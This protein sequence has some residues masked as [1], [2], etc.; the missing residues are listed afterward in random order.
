MVKGYDLRQ[1]EVIDID[2]A[3]RLGFVYDVDVELE[4]GLIRSVI[5]PRVH[6]IFRLFS[7]EQDYVIP[8]ENIKVIGKEIILI[9]NPESCKKI[10]A[11]P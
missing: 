10:S 5:V 4:T 8:W 2:T 7:K 9:R 3:E 11:I 1:R 6:G